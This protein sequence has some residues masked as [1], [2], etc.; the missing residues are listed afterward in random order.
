MVRG[1][2]PGYDGS[3]C[4]R[5]VLPNTSSGFKAGYHSASV[6]LKSRSTEAVLGPA[7]TARNTRGDGGTRQ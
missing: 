6:A 4:P 1:A 7:E 3:A 5:L 2:R